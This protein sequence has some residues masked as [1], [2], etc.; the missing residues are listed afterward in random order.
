MRIRFVNMEDGS[1]I[2][3]DEE[4]SP[5]GDLIPW[6]APTP[7]GLARARRVDVPVDGPMWKQHACLYT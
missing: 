1:L 5:D 7:T 6:P 3:I 2:S 4:P